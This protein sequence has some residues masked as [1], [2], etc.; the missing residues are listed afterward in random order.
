MSTPK[1]RLCGRGYCLTM[2]ALSVWFSDHL[3]PCCGL[4]LLLLNFYLKSKFIAVSQKLVKTEPV[5]HSGTCL[6]HVEQWLLRIH[7]CLLLIAPEVKNPDMK[8]DILISS[9][10]IWKGQVFLVQPLAEAVLVSLLRLMAEVL[11]RAGVEQPS[12]QRLVFF[13]LLSLALHHQTSNCFAGV[14]LGLILHWD[15]SVH[16]LRAAT[17][18]SFCSTTV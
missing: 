16:V 8:N 7:M 1:H 12:Q 17:I 13:A 10:C 9:S 14:G 15:L 18:P 11:H 3:N 2:S 4:L 5:T 6:C